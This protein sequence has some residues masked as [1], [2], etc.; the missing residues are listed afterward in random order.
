VSELDACALLVTALL[1]IVVKVG[2]PV[3]ASTSYAKGLASKYV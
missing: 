1:P 3:T 2:R